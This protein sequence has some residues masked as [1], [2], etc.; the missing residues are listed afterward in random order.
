MTDHARVT[1]QRERPSLPEL[2]IGNED[3][4]LLRSLAAQVAELAARPIE[5]H[6][7]QLWRRLN[8]L[9]PGR[10]LILCWP[11]NSWNEVFPPHALRCTGD[12]ARRWELTLRMEIYW[13][14][15][16][17]DDR[18]IEP[19][20]TV[21]HVYTDSGW[22]VHETRIGGE[23]GGSFVWD[24]PLKSY[25]DM[26]RMVF[27]H[28]DVNREATES[29]VRLAQETLGDILPVR[30]KTTGWATPALSRLVASLRGLQQLL[31]DML[32]QPADLHRLM[33]FLRDGA[34]A[35]LDDLERRGLLCLNNDGAYIGSGGFG[36]TDELPQPDFTG[37][38]RTRDLWG[39][40][41]S[42]ETVGVSPQMFA[43]FIFQYQLP[44]LGRFGLNCYGC[45]EPLETRWH[46]VER[47][48]RLRRVSIPPWSNVAVMAERLGAR[49][50]FSMKPNP[51]DLAMSSFD[52]TMIRSGLRQALRDSRAC[53][54][55]VIMKDT[56]TVRNDPSRLAR[57]V[58]IAREEAESQSLH[59]C[60]A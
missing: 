35:Q 25:D 20:F 5:Q 11:E 14:D 44:I 7:R 59:P 16:L 53:R 32:D 15:V 47:I 1:I 22:G 37:H 50:V 58:R 21:S 40:E 26:S 24:P 42:Q 29:V 2:T 43:E 55:E 46:I 28:I 30:L 3:R 54:V 45:C 13:G 39:F 38:V 19:F 31:Y 23:D 52:E 12:L 41:K 27:P 33:A 48:P 10:P 60:R 51:A 36:W 56:H 34:L 8:A 17:C 6:K 18:V 9:Q 57:W 49:Y 4:M